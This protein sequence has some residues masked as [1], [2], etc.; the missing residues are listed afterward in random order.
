MVTWHRTL[1]L[2][3]FKM[4]LLVGQAIRPLEHLITQ[5]AASTPVPLPAVSVPAH[6]LSVGEVVGG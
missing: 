2:P 4:D 1:G 3:D 5:Q 6:L